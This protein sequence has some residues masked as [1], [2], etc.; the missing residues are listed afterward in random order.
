MWVVLNF[1][2]EMLS[3]VKL[4]NI[5]YL[6]WRHSFYTNKSCIYHK[7]IQNIKPIYD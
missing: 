2:S 6:N 4:A 3:F 1:L 7:Y 5:D